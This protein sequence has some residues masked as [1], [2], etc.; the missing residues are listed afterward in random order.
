MTQEIEKIIMI[1]EAPCQESEA[2]LKYIYYN[3][4]FNNLGG[5]GGKE[6]PCQCRRC[7]RLRFNP[8]VG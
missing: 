2:K 5:A 7:K 6:S 4:V 3:T 8:W 1:F